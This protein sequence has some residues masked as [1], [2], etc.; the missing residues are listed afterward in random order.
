[1]FAWASLVS[2]SFSL[3]SNVRNCNS[4]GSWTSSA[5]PSWINKTTYS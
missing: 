5:K 1:M 4:Y 2:I 3:S